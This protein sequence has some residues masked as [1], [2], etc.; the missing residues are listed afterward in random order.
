[1]K[2]SYFSRFTCMALAC[3]SLNALA[4]TFPTKPIKF[5]VPFPAGSA[6]DNLGR[7]V[8]Q[9]MGEALGQVITVENKAGSNGVIGAELVKASAGDPY[10]LLVTTST[11]QAANVS[12]YKKL[13]YDP[14]KD[15]TPIGKIGVTGFVL[16]VKPDLPPKDIKEFAAFAKSNPGKLAFGH[17]S[18]GSLVSAAQFNHIAGIEAINVPYKGIPPAMIDLIGGQIQYVFVDVGNAATQAAGGKL[19]A[20]GITTAKRSALVPT[21]PP[22]GDTL[23]GYDISAWFGLM[24]PANIPADAAK[25]LADTLQAVLLKPEVKAKIQSTGVDLDVQSPAE[26]AK[27]IDS[28]IKKWASWVKAANIQP[29]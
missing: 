12:L 24:A 20:L 29:E 25:K 9:A 14:V 17:G 2:T 11:T 3:V 22:I 18:S 27:T 23:K 28:E 5:I 10:T 13:N 15:F 26:L 4:Q 19:R 7:V 16:M 6:T 8:A 1:M 21:V